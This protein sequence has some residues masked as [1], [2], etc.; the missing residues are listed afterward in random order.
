MKLSYLKNIMAPSRNRKAK[1]W[2]RTK[3]ANKLTYT[4]YLVETENLREFYIHE[5]EQGFM[6]K[7]LLENKISYW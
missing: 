5:K 7:N 3:K 6:K 4:H 2:E 1:Q